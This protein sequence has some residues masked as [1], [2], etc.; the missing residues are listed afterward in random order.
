MGLLLVHLKKIGSCPFHL[1][2]ACHWRYWGSCLNC[3]V[4][5]LIACDS[6]LAFAMLAL[7]CAWACTTVWLATTWIPLKLFNSVKYFWKATTL[8]ST[9]LENASENLKSVIN[10][11][12][13]TMSLADKEFLIVFAITS[14]TMAL[15]V[16]N[17]SALYFATLALTDSCIVG[18]ITLSA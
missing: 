1:L 18:A 3:D 17:S 8:S 16:I 14:L 9:W 10:I 5:I 11:V 15:F 4:I 13:T 2:I 6:P 7:A 12:S